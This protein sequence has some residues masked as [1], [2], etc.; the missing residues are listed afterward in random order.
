LENGDIVS[1]IGEDDFGLINAQK[2]VLAAQ[3][4]LSA[5]LLTVSPKSLGFGAALTQSTV[6]VQ[7]IGGELSVE[8]IADD[9]A[10]L[11]VEAADVD[12]N[13]LGSY[14]VRV[15]RT[16]VPGSGVYEGTITIES[17]ENSVEVDVTM[18]VSSDDFSYPDAGYHYILLVDAATGDTVS[19]EKA[20]ANEGVYE[21]TFSGIDAGTY[22]IYAGT[23]LDA[24]NYIGDAGEVIG[25]YL[26]LDKPADIIV[27]GDRAGLDFST[28]FNIGLEEAGTAN[29][30][31]T[32]AGIQIFQNKQLAR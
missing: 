4:G 10:W 2:A 30:W 8:S 31:N 19:V 23:D 7:T 1:D 26:S 18:Q 11:S 20:E 25:A 27:T 6:T 22:R 21:F 13:G 24:D 32:D 29:T 5:A 3:D 17:T 14:T 12:E 28:G 9:S 15:D 16:A